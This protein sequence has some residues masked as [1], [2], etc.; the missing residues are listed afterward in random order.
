MQKLARCHAAIHGTSNGKAA[1]LQQG[2]AGIWAGN[3]FRHN[4]ALL[5]Q[6][7]LGVTPC[8]PSYKPQAGQF[9]R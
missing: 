8:C 6:K 7:P 1:Q 3:G 9:G 5:K 4:P 2:V